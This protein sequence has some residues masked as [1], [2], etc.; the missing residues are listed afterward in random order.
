MTAQEFFKDDRF[1]V[2]AGVELTEVLP[3]RARACLR[4]G[5][6]HLNA[7]GRTQGGAIFTL[8][9]LALAAAANSRG[10]LSF[11]L[12]ASLTFL[13]GSG[14]GD[15]L[16]AEASERYTGRTTGYYQ[17]DIT[18]QRGELVAAFQTSVFRMDC[19]VPFDLP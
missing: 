16:W 4:V 2:Q 9:D 13:R 11:S 14:E 1:A 12:S 19:P 6:Q 18:N 7:G 15:T 10:R 8:A 5:R 3:G 17:V